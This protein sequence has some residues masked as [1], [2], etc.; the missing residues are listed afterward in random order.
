MFIECLLLLLR[1]RKMEQPNYLDESDHCF[2]LSAAWWCL[3][4]RGRLIVVG[5]RER[6]SASSALLQRDLWL[7]S[8]SCSL[9]KG[10]LSGALSIKSSWVF[11]LFVA[12]VIAPYWIKELQVWRRWAAVGT[13]WPHVGAPDT[14]KA[15]VLCSPP[16][17]APPV[18]CSEAPFSRTACF[19]LA[20]GSWGLCPNT[21]IHMHVLLSACMHS[22]GMI[23]GLKP[24]SWRQGVVWFSCPLLCSR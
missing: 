7:C 18:T 15:S 19:L 2:L 11:A 3:H 5:L 4:I 17:A 6:C 24:G 8:Q 20:E 1:E 10:L 12:A 14:L 16:G 13:E 23:G 21:F 9:D 22:S